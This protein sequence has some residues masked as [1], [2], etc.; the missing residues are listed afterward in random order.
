MVSIAAAL[1][2]IKGNPLFVLGVGAVE[3][4]CGALGYKWRD[5]QLDPTTLVG[6]FVQQVAMGNISCAETCRATHLST[7]P[8]AYCQARARLPLAVYQGLLTEVVEAVMPATVDQEHL[9]HGHRT[10]HMD[11]SSISMPDTPELIKAFGMPCGQKPGCGFPTAHILV[12]FSAS[13]GLLLDARMSPL[14]TG[15]VSHTAEAH[16]HL[17][18][19]D[20]VIGDDTFGGYAHLASLSKAGLHGLFP[21]HHKRIVDFTKRRPHTAEGNDAVNGLPRS[22]WIKSLGWNDQLVEYPKPK[23]K[24]RYMIK[25]EYDELP[26]SIIVRE[27]RRTV[28][29][30]GLGKVTLTM[31]TTLLDPIAYRAADLLELRQQRWDVETNLGYLKTTMN[32]D[33]LRCMTEDGVRKELAV[34]CLVYNLVRCVMLEAARR[35]EVPVKRISFADALYWLRYARPGDSLPPLKVNPDRPGRH[36]PRCVKRRKKQYDL[37]NKPRDEMKKSLENK[38]KKR[39]RR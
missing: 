27:I 8:Q 4:V 38:R 25:Q 21:T 3:R 5:R 31:A 32:M 30:G 23:I 29:R 10:F 35:Q 16:A 34:F 18:P 2:R 14:R 26:E 22:R 15:D 17:L 19:G 7:T 24:P 28:N 9:W 36:E 13:T 6:S 39:S 20:I 11:G 37:M 12:L 33:V 1:E